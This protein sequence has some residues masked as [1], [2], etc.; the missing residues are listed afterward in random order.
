MAKTVTKGFLDSKVRINGKKV[1]TDYKCHP[2]NYNPYSSRE[3]KYIVMHYTGNKKD[4][5]KANAQYFNRTDC[6]VSA[7]FFVDNSYIYQSVG[8]RDKAWHAGADV[9]Y[10]HADCR[11]SNAFGIEMCCTAGNYKMAKNTIINSAYVC[12]YL[13]KEIGITAST[14]DKYVLR[15]HDV[16][17]KMCPRQ[18]VENPAEW[19]ELKQM[20]KNILNTGSHK[21]P[22]KKKETTTTTT[23]TTKKKTVEELAKEVIA[24]KWGNG[25]TRKNKLTKA[26]YDYAKVQAK[27]D[28]LMGKTKKKTN[29]QIAKEVIE[30]KW[31]NG[32]TRKKKLTDAGYDYKAIQSLVNKM[33]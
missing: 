4:T 3:V 31:G 6:N 32:E 22:K 7:H 21:S 29:E 16:T 30:G 27:V 18:M 23:T 10:V 14:V 5:A 33:V 28:E 12:A 19:T 13:C 25:L 20:V 24:G 1:K 11:N 9:S 8:L 2:G 26:G 17:G 15:H